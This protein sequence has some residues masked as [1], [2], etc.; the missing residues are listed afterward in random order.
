MAFTIC[1]DGSNIVPGGK[2]KRLVTFNHPDLSDMILGLAHPIQG[3]EWMVSVLCDEDHLS[4]V[5]FEKLMAAKAQGDPI[6]L[7]ANIYSKTGDVES[8]TPP[9]LLVDIRP[10]G[11]EWCAIDEPEKFQVI[12]SV[13][14]PEREV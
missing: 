8:V 7:T 1:G 10:V 14:Q 11:S 9:L 12:F 5:Q 3:S 13:I 4:R 6:Q 2:R